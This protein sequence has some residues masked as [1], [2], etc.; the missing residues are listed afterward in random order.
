MARVA[1]SGRVQPGRNPDRRPRQPCY[2]HVGDTGWKPIRPT[3]TANWF[4]RTG[5]DNGF[6]MGFET[7]FRTGSAVWVVTIS[8]NPYGPKPGYEA[9]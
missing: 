7:Q 1:G 9:A 3:P 5:N 4:R 2:N 8:V 6:E